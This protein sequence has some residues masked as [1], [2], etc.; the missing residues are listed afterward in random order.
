[1]EREEVDG[2]G[3]KME[4]VKDGEEVDAASAVWDLRMGV[5]RRT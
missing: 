2:V 4:G 1:M 3:E 5:G